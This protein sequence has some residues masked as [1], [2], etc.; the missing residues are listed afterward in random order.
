MSAHVVGKRVRMGELFFHVVSTDDSV[1]F[2][3]DTGKRRESRVTGHIHGAFA[4]AT[5]DSER[6]IPRVARR[7]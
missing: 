1:A 6:L 5:T 3:L 2:Q 4:A 7:A